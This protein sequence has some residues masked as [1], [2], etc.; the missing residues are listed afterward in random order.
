MINDIRIALRNLIRVPGFA[1]AFVLTLGLGIGAN[2]A[3]F[4]IINGVLL[5]PLPYPEADRIMHLRQPQ[6]A[7]GV[8]DSSF[9]FPEVAYYRSVAKTVDQFVEFG[10]WT[11]NVLGRGEPHRATGGLVTAN[12]FPM[13]GAQ[14][15]LGRMLVSADEAKGAPP[16]VVLTHAYWQRMFGSDPAV[17]GQTL[18]LTVKQAL[19]VGVLKPGSHYATQ[20]TQDFYAN[21]AA[22]DHY[23]SSSMQNE[24]PHRMTTVYARLAPGATAASAQ[25]ELRQASA[26][27]H[28][29]HPEAYP[30]SRGFDVLVTSWKDELTAKAKP[31]LIIL[32]VTTIF[33]LII[34]CANVANLTLT[35]LV[36]RER[37]M[38]I[39]AAL[40]APAGMLRRQLL[41]ENLV[42]SVLGG[43]LGLALAV[44]GL[45][46]LIAYTS[47]FTSRTGEIALDARVLAF[48]LAVATAMAMLFAWAPRLTFMND[49]VRAMSAGG[50]RSTGTR[51]R[52]RAQRAL[53]VSQL[54][55]SFMLL[56]GAGLLTRSLLRLYAVDPGFDLAHVLSLEAPA[57]FQQANPAVNAQRAAQFGRD[58]IERVKGEASVR[59]AAMAS[60]APLA[61]SFPQQREFRIDGA[62]ADAV[63]AGLRTVTRIVSGSYFETIGTPLKAGRSFQTTDTRTSPP[64]VILSESMARY[65]FKTGDPIGR[66]ISWKLTNGITGAVSWSPAA[67][68]VGV[69]ADSRADGVDQPVMH[70]M[71]QPDTQ[72]FAPS[73][74]LVRTSSAPDGLAP[75]VIETIRQLD[76]QR[77]IDHVQTLEEIR[78]ET[79]APQRLNATLIGLFAALALAIAT[80]GVAGVLAFSVSQRTNELGIRMALGAER[81]AI[82]RMILGEGV[83]MALVGLVAGGVAAIPLSALLKGLL[84]GVEPADP[85][86][87][88]VSAVLLVGV[89]LFASWIPA[90]RATVVDPIT[91]LRTD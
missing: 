58:V 60:A 44:A 81:G 36:Q 88:A 80:V 65:Y 34:A 71:F 66:R 74:L 55:A 15:L 78:D 50:G 1:L 59:N 51:G 76:P 18:D 86:T 64:V 16:V 67:E 12:F 89:A 8:E 91:A 70:T 49:P 2:T 37:E 69:V 4:S 28:Q 43:A 77:P 35:R 47:R 75:R 41:A 52:R 84:F 5:R 61:G 9:S 90:R 26:S 53:V 10:D 68:I 54:A 31:T 6:V 14:P 63:G 48:T 33:V 85:P 11:F 38:G 25:A 87:I 57:N 13:L 42:L 40:G 73:T 72:S 7:A 3:I 21:Y 45:N 46:L 79:I 24:W 17:V 23:M 30:Q 82:L 20:R 19:I 62:D 39:R 32:L 29:D 83:A 22:N 56:I 27:L